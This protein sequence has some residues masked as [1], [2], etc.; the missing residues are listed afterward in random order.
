MSAVP[1]LLSRR[2]FH[3]AG[4]LFTAGFLTGGCGGGPDTGS[5]RSGELRVGQSTPPVS[6]D[7]AKAGGESLLFTNAAYEPLINRAPDGSYQPALALSWRYLGSGNTSFEIVLR[8][9]TR[10]SDGTPVDA[11]AVKANIQYFRDAAGQASAFLAAIS[12]VEVVDE[13]TVRLALAE[14]HPQLPAVFTQDLFAGSLISPAGIA[15]AADLPALTFGAGPYQLV[16]GETVAGDHYT[17]ARN[18][19]YWNP[20]AVHY[21][22]VTIKVL[23]N[24]NTAL[25]AIRTGQVDVITGTY[26]IVDGA[27][28]AGLR[29]ASSPNLVMGLQLNDRAGTLSP[30]LGD[31][32][33]RQALN[34]AVDRAKITKALLGEYGVPTEQPAAP[35]GD[36]Y[37]ETSFYSHD[38]LR[39]KQLLAEAG[40]PAGFALPVLIPSN[41]ASTADLVQAVA[42]DLDRIG[43]K[44][45]IT[46]KE[47]TAANMELTRYPASIMGWG[48]LPVYFMGRGLWL[49]DA[50]GLNP[51]HSTDP[52]LE[53]L[54]R[55]AAGADEAARAELDRQ[56]V[57]RV[58]ELGWFIPVCLSPVF[59]FSRA[60]VSVGDTP[61]QAL[62][63]LTSWRPAD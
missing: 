63:S 41:S 61:G 57:R 6:L 59:L 62:P 13:L 33:V 42:A 60:G 19:G 15:R 50:I 12:S 54:D 34:F 17:Y 56:I 8:P 36:G 21:D 53:D 43:V 27:K 29:V 37:N 47:P 45:E 40:Y 24:E 2:A 49:R 4:L 46:A 35:G 23:P 7:P 52:L 3:T 25:A 38:P 51:F 58:V 16:P 5:T 26:A 1:P 9:Q 10:F 32:R 30:P 48:V 44:V 20:A 18:P 28:S 11:E 22:K 39:A 55:Q 14:P 31:V